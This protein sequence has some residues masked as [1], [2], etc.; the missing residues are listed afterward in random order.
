M[1]KRHF[2]VVFFCKKSKTNRKGKAPIYARVATNGS[3][4]R[5]ISTVTSS[6]KNGIRK[7][8]VSTL[9]CFF[10]KKPSLN[11]KKSS[12]SQLSLAVA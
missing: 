8:N 12:D 1:E 11:I 4:A 10:P 3:T 9:G 2:S 7:P 6:R 5:F